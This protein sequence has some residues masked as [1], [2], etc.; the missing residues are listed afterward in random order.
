[1]Q[2]L[3][4][5]ALLACVCETAMSSM[6]LWSERKADAV[7]PLSGVPEI[8]CRLEDVQSWV[9]VHMYKQLKKMKC[10]WCHKSLSLELWELITL[11]LP[12]CKIPTIELAFYMAAEWRTS[13]T[14]IRWPVHRFT[15]VNSPLPF[16]SYSLLMESVLLDVDCTSLTTI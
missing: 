15:D 11:A 1:M 3:S 2:H 13:T 4:Q 9:W 16:P 8:L 10:L 7:A 14:I 6:M 5:C 12:S